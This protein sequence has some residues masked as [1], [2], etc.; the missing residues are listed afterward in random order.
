MKSIVIYLK[1]TCPYCQRALK[2]LNEKVNKEL[3]EIKI[4]DISNKPELRAEMIEK[5][6][7]T[8]VPEIFI[9]EQFI[10][11]CDDLYSLEESGKLDEI[12]Q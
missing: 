12:L 10:G 9:K 11:G 6:G 7:R 1:P 8:T 3:Y 5:S 2:L 4:I